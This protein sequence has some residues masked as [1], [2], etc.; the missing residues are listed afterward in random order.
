MR[1]GKEWRALICYAGSA[2]EASIGSR[3][4]GS[5]L[6]MQYAFLWGK[7]NCGLTR[8]HSA[9]RD[10]PKKPCKTKGLRKLQN[11]FVDREKPNPWA[12][13]WP[14]SLKISIPFPIRSFGRE[15]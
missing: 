9:R 5:E 3:P 10:L 6:V 7:V 12:S 14:I 15:L 4:I 8:C 1:C 2:P 13:I 11:P